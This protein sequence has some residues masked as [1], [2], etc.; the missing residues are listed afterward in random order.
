MTRKGLISRKTKQLTNQLYSDN[1]FEHIIFHLKSGYLWFGRKLI[2]SFNKPA[3]MMIER[4][5]HSLFLS[6][7]QYIYIYIYIYI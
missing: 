3:D 7:S 5:S 4:F 6:L 2:F 1:S